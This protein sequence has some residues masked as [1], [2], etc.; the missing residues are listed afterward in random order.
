MVN[1]NPKDWFG[2]IFK[3]HKS[4][5]FR[6]LFWVI[7]SI[8]IYSFILAYIEIEVLELNFKSTAALHSVLGFVLSILLVFRT[9]TAYDRW[10]EGRR[11]WGTLVNDSRSL[12]LKLSSIPA[13]RSHPLFDEIVV[14][15]SMYPSALANHLRNL[16]LK[17]QLVPEEVHQPIFIEGK[18][19]CCLNQ[20]KDEG[21]LNDTQMLWLNNEIRTY[22]DVCGACE[23]IKNTPIPY[24]YSLFL[25]KF[26]FIYIITMPYGFIREFGYGITLA[27]SFVFYVLASL[28]LIAEEIENPFG[29][30]ANDLELDQ[31]A[32]NIERNIKEVVKHFKG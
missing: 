10:W 11:L 22:S 4:D 23:R 7:V 6:K 25:K 14:W 20:L 24:S 5:T 2:L 30:D 9:N 1:Y 28:E 27:V 21:I 32:I 12:V 19:L 13:L 15:M 16:K 3:F 8:V 17:N 26:I 31:M 29:T 18:I